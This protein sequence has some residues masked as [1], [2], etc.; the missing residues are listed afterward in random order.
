MPDYRILI[1]WLN[2]LDEAALSGGS[3]Q[4][5]LPLENLHSR[6]IA[7]VARSQG[8]DPS[9]TTMTLDFQRPRPLQMVNLIGHNGSFS[10]Q[11]RIRIGDD[12]SWA[13]NTTSY[14]V[15][16]DIWT[17]M[18]NG[19]WD[20]NDYEWEDDDFWLGGFDQEEIQGLTAV[21]THVLPE[22]R[23]GRYLR[24]D[25]LDQ[26]NPDGFF[27]LGRVFAGPAVSPSVN[28]AWGMGEGWDFSG[29][30]IETALSGAEYFDEREGVRVIRFTLQHLQTDEAYSKF[31]EMVRRQ[32]VSKEVFVIPDP[33]DQFNGLKRNFLGRIRQ[34]QS[35][36]EKVQWENG[37]PAHALSLEIK[38]LR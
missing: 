29:T 9:A 10:G 25:I 4:P 27:Q 14:D 2:R 5:S 35:F 13:P 7:K 1:G 19:P 31:L 12:T 28:V 23:A 38:E 3:W 36:L 32:G 8:L 34:P 6:Q 18:Q 16:V 21:S 20:V 37:G 33:S 22:P 30:A 15:T 24:I 11:A 17:G 26:S